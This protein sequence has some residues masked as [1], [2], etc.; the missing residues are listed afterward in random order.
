MPAKEKHQ[1]I[2]DAAL[3]QFTQYG[4]QRTSMNDIAQHAEISR[5]S[6]YSYFQN[7]DEIFRSVSVAVH[8]RL[9]VE[10]D[11]VLGDGAASDLTER[12]FRALFI[13]H[14]RFLNLVLDSSHGAELEDEYSRLC[15]DVVA[16]ANVK[17][18]ARLTA[19]FE[20]LQNGGKKRR[21]AHPVPAAE[22]ARLLNLA[23]AG[24]KRGATDVKQFERRIRGLAAIY[25]QGVQAI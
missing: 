19:V 3:V 7:K 5:A 21:G 16:D 23:A 20:M 24:C 14:S 1:R 10:V 11:A 25:V 13:R 18:E 8:E 2:L 22:A 17:F 15:G 12:V 4:F 6:L 9:L